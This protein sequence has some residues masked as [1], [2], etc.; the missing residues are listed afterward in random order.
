MARLELTAEELKTLKEVLENDIKTLQMEA[1]RTDHR[2]FREIVQHKEKILEK[3]LAM[4][5]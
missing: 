3:I 1:V 5:P 4:L 2:D